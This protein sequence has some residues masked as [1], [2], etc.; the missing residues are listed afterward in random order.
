MK[1]FDMDHALYVVQTPPDENDDTLINP[2]FTYKLSEAELVKFVR[3]RAAND[4]L[5]TGK[6]NTSVIAWR[7]ILKEM[8]IQ[9]KMSTSQARKKWENL[10][11]KYKEMKNPPPGVTVNPTNWQ[12]FSL[13]DDAME[14]RLND[15][16]A[17]VSTAS[18][19]DDSD[20]RPDRPRK[21]GRDSYQSEIEFLVEGEES[22]LSEETTRDRTETGSDRDE[23]EQERVLLESDRAA[24]ESERMVLEREKMV[25][26]RERAGLERELAALDRDRASLEREKAA[27]ERDRAS[28]E[29]ERAQL[30][31]E[32]AEM[33][34]ERAKLER[35]RATL[36]R[37]RVG[38]GGDQ[39]VDLNDTALEDGKLAEVEME[40]ASIERRQKFLDLFE[41]LIENF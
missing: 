21:R 10:K 35:N 25:L 26:D 14:G 33:D 15:S 1:L 29:H 2:D 9:R 24:L 31:K 18:L 40:T 27:V 38:A 32:R 23:M 28:V 20:F 7:A 16:E 12:W 8:G 37:Q 17:M 22:R 30:E 34:K 6:R 4:A 13:M 41:K 36:E 3:L 5:F 19:G 39:G 11:K